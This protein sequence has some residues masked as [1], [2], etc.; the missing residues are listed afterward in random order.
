MSGEIGTTRLNRLLKQSCLHM[1]KDI[2]VS[3]ARKPD[4][5]DDTMRDLYVDNIELCGLMENIPNVLSESYETNIIDIP[6]TWTT[7]RWSNTDLKHDWIH[8]N[9]YFQCP[10]TGLYLLHLYTHFKFD[11]RG[12]A[13]IR[14][15]INNSI[16][17]PESYRSVTLLGTQ[18]SSLV[19]ICRVPLILKDKIY[20]ECA[21]SDI[22]INIQQPYNFM[23]DVS[24]PV[25]CLFEAILIAADY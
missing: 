10:R 9:N 11:I 8:T 13:S 20:C 4:P 1:L 6:K 21:S 17:I 7:L 22:M 2:I 23:N 18:E 16:I 25:S 5:V 24:C 19:S 3:Y 12:H 14:L 15:R